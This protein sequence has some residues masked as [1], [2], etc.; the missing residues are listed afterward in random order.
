MSFW[1]FL[2]FFKVTQFAP[3]EESYRTESETKL[4]KKPSMQ[5]WYSKSQ[6]DRE[7]QAATP[8]KLP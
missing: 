5:D 8:R 4:F 2:C 6:F 3:I 1:I 7:A